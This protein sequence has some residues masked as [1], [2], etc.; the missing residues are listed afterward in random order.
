MASI[1]KQDEFPKYSDA[2][3]LIIISP[4]QQYHLH[5]NTLRS[6]SEL[7]RNLLTPDTAARLSAKARKAGVQ[8][9][10]RVE[11]QLPDAGEE[12]LG[13]LMPRVSFQ[14]SLAINTFISGPPD[15][16]H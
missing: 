7:F 5:A 3:V 13:W 9:R 4:E 10:W 2:D 6:Q 1:M 11:L 12:G 16:C 14:P 8:L 15:V